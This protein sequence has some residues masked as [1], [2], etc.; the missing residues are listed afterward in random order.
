MNINPHRCR[1]RA[2]NTKRRTY[3]GVNVSGRDVTSLVEEIK[4]NLDNNL[5]LP[6]GYYIQYGGA[7]E[8]FQEASERLQ[9]VVPIALISFSFC[10]TRRSVRSSRQ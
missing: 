3:V 7:F 1:F 6:P 2:R 9:V 8:N 5:E 10:S 4:T